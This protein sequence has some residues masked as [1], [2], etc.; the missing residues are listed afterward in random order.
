MG[1]GVRSNDLKFGVEASGVWDEG[2]MFGVSG[3][4]SGF[5][6]SLFRTRVSDFGFRDWGLGL[7]ENRMQME[8][9]TMKTSCIGASGFG[10]RVLDFGHQVSGFGFLV[11]HADRA[12]FA[13]T[14]ALG[15]IGWG[16]W[17]KIRGCLV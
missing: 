4:G 16:V 6:D 9:S 5:R 12:S 7:G 2:L 17:C 3:L 10:F 1:C 15:V 13:T 8:K 11:P 14:G